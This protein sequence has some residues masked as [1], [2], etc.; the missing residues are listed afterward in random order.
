[1]KSCSPQRDLD[2]LWSGIILVT[3]SNRPRWVCTVHRNDLF[4]AGL[5]SPTLERC[6]SAKLISPARQSNFRPTT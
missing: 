6:T 5:C 1:M 2:E 3:G 4:P